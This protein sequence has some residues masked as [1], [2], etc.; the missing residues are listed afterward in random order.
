M[1]TGDPL[2][3]SLLITVVA[4]KVLPVGV[5]ESLKQA[6]DDPRPVSAHDIRLA[7]ELHYPDRT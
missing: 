2:D 1:I 4:R 6:L 3:V 5:L 7:L